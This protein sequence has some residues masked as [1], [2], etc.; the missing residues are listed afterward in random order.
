MAVLN[1]PVDMQKVMHLLIVDLIL[2]LLFSR[3]SSETAGRSITASELVSAVGNKIR[4][5]AM[6]VRIP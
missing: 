6:P 5:I 4:G 1:T 3:F 2:L